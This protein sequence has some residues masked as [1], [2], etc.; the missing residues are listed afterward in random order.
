MGSS[1]I[2]GEWGIIEGREGARTNLVNRD[3]KL[4]V[5]LRECGIPLGRLLHHL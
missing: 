1:F 2:G 4:I 3:D 5:I